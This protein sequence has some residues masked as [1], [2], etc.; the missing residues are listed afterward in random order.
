MPPVCVMLWVLYLLYL[1]CL[2]C[3]LLVCGAGTLYTK[4]R[5][6]GKSK[7]IALVME[8]FDGCYDLSFVFVVFVA[9]LWSWSIKTLS[10]AVLSCL[11]PHVRGVVHVPAPWYTARVAG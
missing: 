11:V 4:A 2:S 5:V 6:S 9:C 1:L 8:V 7:M 3:L 10:Q